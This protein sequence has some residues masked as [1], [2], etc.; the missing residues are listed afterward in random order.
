MKSILLV[1]AASQGLCSLVI[2][3]ELKGSPRDVAAGEEAMKTW[4]TAADK[5]REQRIG[6]WREARFGCFIHWGV[7]ADPAG[8]FQGKRSGSYSEH[9]MRSNKIP[10]KTYKQEIVAN[11][12]PTKFNADEW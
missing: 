9:I 12:N 2:A 7:Y 8:E 11:F 4:W 1:L 3:Q 5:T 6:W 10:L